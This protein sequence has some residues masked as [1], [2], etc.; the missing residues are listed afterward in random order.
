MIIP[1]TIAAGHQVELRPLRP[2]DF[3]PGLKEL[4]EFERDTC[5]EL[6]IDGKT[7]CL[8]GLENQTDKDASMSLRVLA[9][10]I[11]GLL[12]WLKEHDNPVPILMIVLYYSIKYPWTETKSVFEY[13]ELDEQWTQYLPDFR[14]EVI[15]LGD[16]NDDRSEMLTSDFR[17]I[18]RWIKEMRSG[19]PSKL[20]DVPLNHPEAVLYLMASV[21]E[22]DPEHSDYLKRASSLLKK[23]DTF[24][25]MISILTP[26]QQNHYIQLGKDQGLQLGQR[27]L[28]S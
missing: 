19:I 2:R 8:I 9:Y 14:T 11:I 1:K 7:V 21:L 13:L 16:P 26:E 20:Y 15:D 23:K 24:E 27:Q 10:N 3:Y 12:N 22:M 5:K 25:H 4:R 18:A 17:L 28:N 6:V